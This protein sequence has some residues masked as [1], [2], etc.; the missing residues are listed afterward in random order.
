MQAVKS[1][2]TTNDFR[3]STKVA[4]RAFHAVL[5][6][7]DPLST[8]TGL[9]ASDSKEDFVE[10]FPELTKSSVGGGLMVF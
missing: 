2:L 8:F 1:V 7:T 10:Y 4:I 9:S 5:S 6:D 3:F